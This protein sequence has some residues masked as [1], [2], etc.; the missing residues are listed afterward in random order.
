[1]RL[2]LAA[3]LLLHSQ[4]F[5]EIPS[6]HTCLYLFNQTATDLEIS[7]LLDRKRSS[8]QA[9]TEFFN[10]ALAVQIFADKDQPG[11]W[12]T[13]NGRRIECEAPRD[14]LENIALVRKA[15]PEKTF[16]SKHCGRKVFEELLKFIGV[17]GTIGTERHTHETMFPIPCVMTGRAAHMQVGR[18]LIC[19]GHLVVQGY[20]KDK[21]EWHSASDGFSQFGLIIQSQDRVPGRRKVGSVDQVAFVE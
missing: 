12:T 9:S 3:Y 19:C 4:I 8:D 20:A 18:V 14:Q 1:M 5:Q 2:L 17:Y 6:R 21:L 13:L 10:E 7:Q 16:R 15:S 11:V